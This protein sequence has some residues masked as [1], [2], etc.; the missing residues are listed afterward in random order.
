[1]PLNR[2]SLLL[3]A[4][5]AATA[6]TAVARALPAARGPRV[7]IVGGGFAGSACALELRSRYP[8]IELTLIDPDGHYTTCPVSNEVIIGLRGI[9]SITVSRRGLERAGARVVRARVAAID[10]ERRTLRLD[11]G[12][13]LAF[14]R[15]VVAP[16]IRF[17]WNRIGGY[18]EAAAQI[19][20]HA[21]Q[22]GSQTTLL[23]RQLRAMEDGGT[24]AISV[25][26][27]LM[28]CPPAPYE[29]ASLIADYLK[30]HKPRSKILI[31]D[32]N[33]AFP[34]QGLFMS[35]WKL[36]YGELIEW[37]PVTGDGAVVRV[38]AARRTLYTAHGSHTVAVANVV[39]PQAPA[40]LAPAAGLASEHG[41][42]PV[43]PATFES[44]LVSGI[45]VIGDACIAGAMPKSASAAVSQ[46]R[47][48]AAAIGALLAETEAPAPSF[49]SICYS[50]L[51][52]ERAV[53]FPGRFTISDGEIIAAATA[54]AA[55]TVSETSSPP[56]G[57]TPATTAPGTFDDEAAALESLA[58][59]RWYGD[60]R[61]R[62][63]AE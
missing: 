37:I 54:P 2:R 49:E 33:N 41:W 51:A 24:L 27:G 29:R 42:C 45:H 59:A 63:F 30:R 3:T 20:P 34:K 11:S 43:D 13:R 14:D 28:R 18:D 53:A 26:A 19:M 7:V 52:P 5:A 1:L 21:W 44:K 40:E 50:H 4:A 25:P 6:A 22:A 35:A 56:E 36:L 46:A 57:E 15:L 55:A 60:I 17:L 62:A 31:L 10:A 58:A 47:Q 16:G 38:D 8:R 23:A 32:A 12:R 61:Q 39:P 9:A 48:C